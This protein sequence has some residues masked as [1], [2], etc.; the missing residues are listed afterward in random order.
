[1]GLD[2]AVLTAAYGM[3][4]DQTLPDV[5]PTALTEALN[6]LAVELAASRAERATLAEQLAQ[7][8]EVLRD[9]V[10]RTS[11]IEAAHVARPHSTESVR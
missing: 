4:Q 5:A 3:P 9:L 11:A 1:M 7:T 8:D 2:V 6:A 10:A